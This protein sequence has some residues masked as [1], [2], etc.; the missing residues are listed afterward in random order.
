M[1]EIMTTNRRLGLTLTILA[2][3]VLGIQIGQGQTQ[4]RPQRSSQQALTLILEGAKKQLTNPAQYSQTYYRI[5]YPGGDVPSDRGACTDVIIRA[6][7]N[8]GYDLQKL[9]HEDAGRRNYPAIGRRRDSNIDHRR[10]RNLIVWFR[11]HAAELSLRTDGKHIEN[12]RPGH[13]VFW[14]LPNG[15][16]HVG[17]VSDKKNRRGVPYVIHNIWQTAEE[18][19][20]LSY[21]LVAHFRFPR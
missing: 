17:I 16:D 21:R 6:F 11:A 2:G 18:D 15:L 8:A 1:V 20:L 5:A 7:R 13:V 14:K 10:C 9:V 4:S 19:V 3:F 12:F